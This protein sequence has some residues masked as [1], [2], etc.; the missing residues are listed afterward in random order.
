M[1]NIKDKPKKSLQTTRNGFNLTEK[2]LLI[3][4][5]EELQYYRIDDFRIIQ[6][7]KVGKIELLDVSENNYVSILNKDGHLLHIDPLPESHCGVP[8]SVNLGTLH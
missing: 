2:Y 7:F 8:Q 6:T 1:H 4:L 3:R 5:A